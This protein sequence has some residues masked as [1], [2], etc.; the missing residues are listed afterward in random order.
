MERIALPRPRLDVRDLQVVLAL[1]RAGSTARAAASLHLT[2]SAVSRGLLLAEEKIGVRLF[3]RTPRGLLPTPAGARLIEGAGPVLGQ[4]LALEQ[5]TGEV[6]APLRLRIVCECYTAYRWLPS[7]LEELKRAAQPLE[8]K[9]AIEHTTDPVSGLLSGSVDVALLTTSRIRG[10]LDEAPLF[11]DELIFLLAATH[12][13]AA[14]R[15]LSADDLLEH[16]LITLSQTPPEASRWF[17][18]RVFGRRKPRLSGLRYPL[19][20]AVVDAARAGLGVAVLSEWV[21]SPYLD[22]RDLVVRRLQRRPLLRPWRMAWR[23]EAAEGARRLG[24]AISGAPPRLA[25]P[26]R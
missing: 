16:R 20:E 26:L 7:A 25:D 24:A 8:V 14:K 3:E 21:A 11:D 5:S 6:P 13:L 9:L 12:P 4:L 23:R 17:V 2:Q 1:A 22:G 19:T 15:Q 18:S 10:G